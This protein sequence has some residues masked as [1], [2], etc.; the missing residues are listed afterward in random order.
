NAAATRIPTTPTILPAV[1][2]MDSQTVP[3]VLTTLPVASKSSSVSD[4]PSLNQSSDVGSSTSLSLLTKSIDLG[5]LRHSW[6]LFQPSIPICL[7]PE[8]NEGTTSSAESPS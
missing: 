7:M 3:S 4:P 1:S 6:N 2:K 5:P 8:M